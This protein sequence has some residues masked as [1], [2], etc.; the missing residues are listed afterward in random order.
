MKRSCLFLCCTIF[1]FSCL[2]SFGQTDEAFQLLVEN[3][4]LIEDIH[5][6]RTLPKINSQVDYIIYKYYK[7]PLKKYLDEG[8]VGIGLTIKQN[9]VIW[10]YRQYLDGRFV[11]DPQSANLVIA[12]KQI[13]KYAI[14]DPNTVIS[15]ENIVQ[16]SSQENVLITISEKGINGETY[17]I[18]NTKIQKWNMYNRY[19][20]N[21]RPSF[22][23]VKEGD[24]LTFTAYSAINEGIIYRRIFYNGVLVEEQ[25]NRY[26]NVYT[27]T[28]GNGKL[29]RYN[30]AGAVIRE[31]KL[32]RTI[33]NG[34][35]VYEQ[36]EHPNGEGSIYI[37]SSQNLLE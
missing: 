12:N 20:S 2:S 1:L 16:D 21:D 34:V 15:K 27:V 30:A 4:L 36:I 33:N 24:K 7:D 28:N 29:L 23:V 25:D 9:S 13:V 22:E 26:R 18:E 6:Y 3:P 19:I 10:K 14:G 11:D 8:G 31:S 37:A 17:S 32:Q 35:I 5:V